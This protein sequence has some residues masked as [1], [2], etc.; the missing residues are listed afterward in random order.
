[1]NTLMV[2]DALKAGGTYGLVGESTQNHY[3]GPVTAPVSQLEWLRESLTAELSGLSTDI[4]DFR[5]YLAPYLPLTEFDDSVGVA[6][7]S[8]AQKYQWPTSQNSPVEAAF[9]NALTELDRLRSR[10]RYIKSLVLA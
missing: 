4:E 6:C 7:E 8:A 5:V 9:L 3:E 10:L 2:K 1:G